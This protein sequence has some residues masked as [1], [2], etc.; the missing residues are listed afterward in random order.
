[1]NR[2]QPIASSSSS[3]S[4]FVAALLRCWESLRCTVSGWFFQ[5]SP[6]SLQSAMQGPGVVICYECRRRVSA[7]EIRAGLHDHPKASSAAAGQ[8]AQKQ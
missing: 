3:L 4:P 1:M 2:L 6:A 5:D 7:A 8:H